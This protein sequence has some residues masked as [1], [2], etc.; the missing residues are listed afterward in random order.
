VSNVTGKTIL[1]AGAPGDRT[2]RG[3]AGRLRDLGAV[4]V[5]AS[6]DFASLDDVRRV[7]AEELGREPRIDVLVTSADAR[8]RRLT[9][10]GDGFEAMLQVNALGPHLLCRLLTDR[11]AASRGRVLAALSRRDASRGLVDLDD[12][13]RAH[14]YRARSV[15]AASK[16]AGALLTREHARRVATVDVADFTPDVATLVFLAGTDERLRG[17]HFVDARRVADPPAWR[18]VETA[19]RL[20][21]LAA[22]RLGLDD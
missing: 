19:R 20:W 9:L 22:T 1:V 12:L 3:A 15:Y 10:T 5:T 8:F 7:A 6:V 16:L 4:V 14:G 2:T 18:D 17:G 21:E 13:D 11:L